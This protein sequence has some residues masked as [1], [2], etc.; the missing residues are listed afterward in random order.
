MQSAQGKA[1]YGVATRA[2]EKNIPVVVIAGSIGDGA[3]KVYSYG[4]SAFFA[5]VNAST[6][7]SEAMKNTEP[8]LYE[9]T[10]N[11]FKLLKAYHK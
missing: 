2:K 6:T 4:V 10:L 11:I 7:L 9:N 5:I 1:V 8:L 3:E